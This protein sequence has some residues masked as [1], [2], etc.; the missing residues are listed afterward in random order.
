MK[1]ELPADFSDGAWQGSPYG[2]S[3]TYVRSSEDGCTAGASID[4]LGKKWHL[5][6][7]DVDSLAL[8]LQCGFIPFPRGIYRNTHALGIGWT[9]TRTGGKIETQFDFPYLN[10]ASSERSIPETGKL[11]SELAQAIDRLKGRAN[12]LMLSSGKDSTSLALAFAEAGIR[13]TC[14]T[15]GQDE[16]D[17]EIV[18]AKSV[19]SHLGFPH[20]SVLTSDLDS[21]SFQDFGKISE[22]CIDKVQMAYFL[23]MRRIAGADVVFDGSGNDAYIGHVPPAILF[24]RLRSS[25]RIPGKG[26]LRRIPIRKFQTARLLRTRSELHFDGSFLHHGETRALLGSGI[27]AVDFW[28]AWDSKL[29]D[30][31]E[32]DFRAMTRGTHSDQRAVVDKAR[33]GCETIGARLALPWCDP[34]VISYCFNLPEEDR[35]DRS[36]LINKTLVRKM[37]SERLSYDTS[38]NTKRFF[39]FGATPVLVRFEKAIDQTIC[40]S[41]LFDA[42]E[43]RKLLRHL[44]RFGEKGADAILR[45]FMAAC[46]VTFKHA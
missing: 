32:F 10:S 15:F 24:E 6:D 37:L 39:E 29:H 19:C 20:E 7:I 25:F 30:F 31:D 9:A 2:E 27:D 17:F 8:L 40:E 22:P 44:N 36:R 45:T 23:C 18:Y 4:A 12:V 14:I 26:L 35:F 3:L 5:S 43:A 42:N 28:K 34:S 33:A 11:L 38:V 46:W 13:P 16:D 21:A 1:N 41:P